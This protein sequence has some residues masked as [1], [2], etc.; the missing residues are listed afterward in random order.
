MYVAYKVQYQLPLEF[1]PLSESWGKHT[2]EW[3]L[4][5]S[6]WLDFASNQFGP[7]VSK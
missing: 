3:A 2:E 4:L 6:D 7:N 1:V 5:N